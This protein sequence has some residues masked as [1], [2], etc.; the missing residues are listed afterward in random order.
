MCYD[1]AYMI[2]LESIEDYFGDLIFDDPQISI[3]F[4][5]ME[6]MQGVAVFG[7]HPI[8]YQN[9]DDG[10]LHCKLM[11][12]GI[13]PYYEKEEPAMMNRNKM[14]NIRAERVLDDPKSYW[15]KIRNR[16]C[17]IP[18]SHAYEHRAIAGWKK[19]VPYAI[20]PSEKMRQKGEGMFGLPGLYSVAEIADKNTGELVRRWTFGM[21][22][23]AANSLMRNIHNDGEN[24]FRMP[25][26]LPYDMLMEFVSNDLSESRYREII[27]YEI[28]SE[29]L[30]YWPVWTLRTSKARPDEKCKY[31]PFEWEGLVELGMGN[32]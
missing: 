10:K 4:T 3:D 32:G 12:W 26:F 31:E 1:I 14:L 6:H 16:R 20:R 9:R 18:L 22:T 21:I 7:K 28:P 19:K 24:A 5:P 2:T 25:L 27:G 23:R 8:I 13:I 15:Y 17:I 29:E 11:E 30:E